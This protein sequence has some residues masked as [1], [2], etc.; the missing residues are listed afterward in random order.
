MGLYG[1]FGLWIF[2]NSHSFE[3]R[4]DVSFG[5]ISFRISSI[6]VSFILFCGL[7]DIGC[8][9]TFDIFLGFV[10]WDVFNFG[11]VFF[12]IHNDCNVIFVYWQTCHFGV[13]SVLEILLW[14]DCVLVVCWIRVFWQYSINRV[15]LLEVGV[16]FIIGIGV[17]YLSR[18][19]KDRMNIT[20]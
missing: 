20:N 17:S 9:V 1:V 6:I 7:F 15:F 5:I 13:L 18:T 11:S 16:T 19:L 10:W 8:G 12:P 4:L 2:G 3:Q 14:L